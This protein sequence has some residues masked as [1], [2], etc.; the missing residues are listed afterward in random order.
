MP[1]EA[2]VPRAIAPFQEPINSLEIHGF[3]DASSGGMCAAVYTVA[4]Q[5]SGLTS[6]RELLAAKTRLAKKTSIH[7][8]VSDGCKSYDC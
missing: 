8:K 3:G 2:V 5:P 1:S 4:T 6:S 7:S